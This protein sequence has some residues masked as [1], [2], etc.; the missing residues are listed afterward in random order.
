MKIKKCKHKWYFLI[1]D[2]F[3]YGNDGIY[4]CKKCGLIKEI[5]NGIITYKKENSVKTI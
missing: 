3:R 4:E 2:D 1:R 5:K